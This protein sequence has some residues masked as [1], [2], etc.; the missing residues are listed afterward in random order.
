MVLIIQEKVFTEIQSLLADGKTD[1]TYQDYSAMRYL[2][3][4]LKETMRMYTTVPIISRKI[5]EDVVLR[6]KPKT[7]KKHF[8]FLFSS[9]TK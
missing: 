8:D 6:S 4:V 7:K 3:N 1:L 9:S 5:S 2:E